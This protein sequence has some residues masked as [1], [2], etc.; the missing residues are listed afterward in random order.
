MVTASPAGAS[1]EFIQNPDTTTQ[2]SYTYKCGMGTYGI[3]YVVSDTEQ[4]H[5]AGVY[6]EDTTYQA[7]QGLLLLR[8]AI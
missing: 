6:Y 5:W 1:F 7:I 2:P 8:I 3:V 4:M